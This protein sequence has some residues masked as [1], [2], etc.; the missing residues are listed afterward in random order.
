MVHN[1]THKSSALVSAVNQIAW[2]AQMDAVADQCLQ[3]IACSDAK[4]CLHISVHHDAT[5][6]KVLFGA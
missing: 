1:K 6:V 5:P 4:K 3:L 2:L